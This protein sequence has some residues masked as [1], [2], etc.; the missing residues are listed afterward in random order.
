MKI[1]LRGIEKRF[2]KV[3]AL[4]GLDLELPHG[5]KIGLIGPNGSGKTTL[6]RVLL[7]LVEHRGEVLIDG[8]AIAPADLAARLGYVPQIA[9]QMAAT[10]GDL[11]RAIAALR[12]LAPGAIIE[13]AEL[14]GLAFPAVARRPF[15]TLSGGSKQKLA[16]AMALAARP[17]LLVLDEPTASLDAPSRSRFFELQRQLAGDAT[18]VL[19]SHRL[20][21]I[22]SLVDHVVALEDGRVTYDGSATGYLARRVGGL[23]EL[24]VSEP[25]AGW[26]AEHGFVAGADGWWSRAVDRDTKLALVPSALAALGPSLQDL[27]VRD[28]DLLEL[29]GKAHHG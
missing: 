26:L 10:C 29:D 5:A 25:P 4:R 6:I 21:E 3:V 18:I 9:P 14:L 11:V 8:A 24:R 22:R 20:E 2:G 13:L 7:G 15:R 17:E 28:V 16:I 19:C 12:G 1:T 27:V 23:L